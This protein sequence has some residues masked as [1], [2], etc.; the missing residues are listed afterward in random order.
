VFSVA[1]LIFLLSLFVSFVFSL[2]L[3]FC[4]IKWFLIVKCL[5]LKRLAMSWLLSN[6][7]VNIIL[8]YD[9]LSSFK[10]VG[11]ALAMKEAV[12]PR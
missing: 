7:V 12:V 6:C 9:D 4:N 8:L 2:D 1:S 5:T 3:K 10:N 11:S